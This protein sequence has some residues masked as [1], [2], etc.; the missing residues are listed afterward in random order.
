MIATIERNFDLPVY[1]VG[2]YGIVLPK[3]G[4]V[5]VGGV[6]CVPLSLGTYITPKIGSQTPKADL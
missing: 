6:G 3:S 4:T 2:L 5:V 1:A